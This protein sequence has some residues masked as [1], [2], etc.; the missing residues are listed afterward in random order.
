MRLLILFA[1]QQPTDKH[2]VI[3]SSPMSFRTKG[4]F[5]GGLP[6]RI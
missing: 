1:A 2:P 6:V 3:L 4:G 5:K